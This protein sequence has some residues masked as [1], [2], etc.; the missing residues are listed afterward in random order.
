MKSEKTGDEADEAVHFAQLPHMHL[1]METLHVPMH[2]YMVTTVAFMYR[3][4]FTGLAH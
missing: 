3:S 1:A 4:S 2:I